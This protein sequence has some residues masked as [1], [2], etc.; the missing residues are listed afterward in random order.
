MN[1]NSTSQSQRLPSRTPD[2]STFHSLVNSLFLFLSLSLSVHAPPPPT[3]APAFYSLFQ[4][5]RYSLLAPSLSLRPSSLSLLD[6]S[7]GPHSSSSSGESASGAASRLCATEGGGARFSLT[8]L[9]CKHPKRLYI[10]THFIRDKYKLY[11][12]SF[13]LSLCITQTFGQTVTPL[14]GGVSALMMFGARC[15][16]A[17]SPLHLMPACHVVNTLR[18]CA[19]EPPS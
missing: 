12:L 8:I 17:P 13:P 1:A 11:T 16:C 19:R 9:P 3:A 18:S 4:A 5:P 10:Y 14:A 15:P 7:R 6:R 2:A